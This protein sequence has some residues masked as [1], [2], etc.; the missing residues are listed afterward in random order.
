M[1]LFLH[2]FWSSIYTIVKLKKIPIVLLLV[3]HS[4]LLSGQTTLTIEGTVEDNYISGTWEGVN[5]PRNQPT[6]FTYRN[7]SVTSVNASGYML[8]AGDE[9]LSGTNNNLE[10]EVITGNR[11]TW[12]G[13][14][15]Q[16][17]THGVFT[18][19]NINAVLKYNY[20]ENVPMGLIR[21][22]NG[23]TNTSGGI[24]YN[25]VNK[26]QATG[27]VVKGMN[28]VNI[29]NNT[30]Y[31]DQ[32]FYG[33]PG[34]GT[35]RGLVDIYINTDITPN[36]SSRGT[37]IKNNI[38]Y[39]K[40]Q[41][42][43]IYIYESDCLNGFESDYNLFY[44][45][46]GTP[47]FNY[48]GS[49]KTF[50]QWQALGYDAHS[51]VVNPDFKD[52][53]GFVP[54]A[55]LDYGTDLGTT[56]QK[57]LSENAVWGATDPETTNQN[58]PWQV[59]ARI[60]SSQRIPVTDIY[61]TGAGGASTITSDNGTLQLNATVLPSNATDKTITWS[62]SNGADKAFIG[63][64][65]LVTAVDNGTVTAMATARDGS[66]ITGTYNITISN[67]IVPVSSI[68]VSGAGGATIIAS[69][70]GSLQLNA[71]VLPSGASNKTVTWSIVS[72]TGHATI[73]ATGLVTAVDNGTVTARASANDGSNVSGSMVIT[74]SNQIIRVTGISVTGAG[75]A[76]T[77]TTDHGSLQLNETVLPV[78]ATDKTVTWSIVNGSGQATISATGIVT[79]VENGVVT[80]RATAN[81]GSNVYGT[82]DIAI[83]NQT[84]QVIG[85]TI[86]GAGGA[87]TIIT[88]DGTLQISAVVLPANATNKTVTWSIVNGTELATISTTGLVTA[89]DNGA[90]TIRAT[91]NDGSNV[92]GTLVITIS[93]QIVPVTGINLIGSGGSST[94]TI[95]NG[96][97]QVS[98]VVL[99]AN[100]TNKSVTWSLINGTGQA[101][102]NA[103][104]IV[105]A[106][107]NG[108]VTARATANDGSNIFGSLVIT[109]SNQIIPVTS[110]S[111]TG[112]GGAT[113]ITTDNGSLQLSETVLPGNSTIKSVTWSIFI[114][115]GQALI[116]PSGLLTALDNGIVTVRATANDGSGVFGSL[117]ITISNQIIPV[118]NIN[119]TGA[120]GST[121]ITA[122]NG[123]LQLTA[124][125]LP[126]DATNK[127]VT[128]TMVNGSGQGTIDA[129]GLVTAIANGTVTAVATASDASGVIG[130]LAVTINSS[131]IP[132]TSI[133]VTG[134]GGISTIT[135]NHGSLQLSEAVLPSNATDNTVTWTL[136]NGTGQANINSTGL[137]TAVDNGTVTARATANDGSGVFGNLVITISNQT[138][139]V[140]GITISGAGGA[141]TITTDDGSLQLIAT[142]LP[143]DA[144]INS[145]TWSI[146]NG[147]GQA[148]ISSG[149]LVTAIN[150]GTVTATATANDGSGVFGSM[151][152]NL[153]NQVV[154]VT[155]I[156]VSGAGG[157]TSI[158][159]D[160]GTLQLSVSV[161]PANATDNTVI[162]SIV[163]STGQATISATG[164]VTAIDNGTVTARATANDGSGISGTLDINISDQM[165]PVSAV[166]VRG[167]GGATTI[168]TDNGSLQLSAELLPVNATDQTVTWSLISGASLANISTTGLVTALDNGTITV[169]AT[170][171]D[172]SGVY[173][174]LVITI[175]N[176]VISVTSITV[177]GSGGRTTI[178]NDNGTL[179]LFASV[180]PSNASNKAVTWS[181]VSGIGLAVINSSG[182]VTALDN[183]SV[184]ARATARDGSGVYGTIVITISNQVIPVTSISVTGTGSETTISTDNGSLQLTATV[185]PVNATNKTVTWS[186][187]NGTG[188]ATINSSGLVTAVENGTVT[189]MA[190]AN[191]G[192][193]V[194][195]N[196]VITISNQIVPVTGITVAGSGGATIITAD[197]G[198]LQLNAVVLPANATDKTVTWSLINGNGR[199][200]INSTGL[201]SAIDNGTV[202]AIATANDGSGIYASLV[203]DIF[204]QVIPVTGI[205]VTGSGGVSAIT[206]NNGTLQMSAVVMPANAS[207]KSVTWTLV[208]G[209]GLAI[210]N[211][212][213]FV[214][215]INNGA[216]T[217]RATANDGSGVFGEMLITISNQTGPVTAITVTGAGGE[218]SINTNKGSLQLTA[219]IVPANATIQTVSWSFVSGTGLATINATGLVSAIENGTVTVRATA[220]DGS[221]VYG[222]IVITISNQLIQITGI[223][224]TGTGGANFIATDNGTLQLSSVIVPAS[225]LNKSVTW[226]IIQGT[227]QATINN[228]GLVTAVDNGTVTAMA[229]ANDG[230]G[231]YGVMVIY[232]SAQIT[233][234]SSITVTGADGI[235]AI[236]DANV[237]IQLIARVMPV[238]ATNSRVTWSLVKGRE[239]AAIDST[240]LVTA[241]NNGI[242]TV[243]ATANDGSGVYGSMVIPI[244]VED[245]E[246]SLSSVTRDEI[247]IKLN[248]NYFSWRAGLYSIQGSLLQSKLVNS[249]V[250]VF[251]ISSLHSGLYIVVLSKGKNIRMAKVIKP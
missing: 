171:N 1:C 8:Q 219:V 58:G 167:A 113:T 12:N 11:F 227:G 145:V 29:Y 194:R 43:N 44:C 84:I 152:L 131:L 217:V 21:K 65:G 3:I 67:Q 100:A 206:V 109:I 181:I 248:N 62:I 234:V 168:T 137:V 132:V 112:A 143:V 126:A 18:G 218:T 214:T 183:G 141:T 108:T 53:T 215:A 64:N 106:I 32:V 247:K 7:N 221:G 59:G 164:L 25:I 38:F 72:G 165:V 139:L 228:I 40:H 184:T 82:I 173:G 153:S 79:A 222:T 185:L 120:G 56:W 74:I 47:L 229:T 133:A 142:V 175:T 124:H 204:N 205:T 138:I 246:L 63:T 239:L 197:N 251:D 169:R 249:D 208:N 98:A 95:D 150:N 93:N 127:N 104:G 66:G 39:T 22:S 4:F 125:V 156:S 23:M 178:T 24:A 2:K 192:S 200:V 226:S 16:S 187:V 201:V 172:G 160:N 210:I 73:N 176:Q 107:D 57:G 54:N 69:D 75:G 42:Y 20:L 157:A 110:I 180:L 128:W 162:W 92:Y 209:T 86:T 30:L 9:G 19:F 170:A 140:T 244:F 242:V 231:V 235:T 199:A 48:L 179:Q 174:T 61:I 71:T 94:I 136:I 26:T 189:A 76:T 155:N 10:G 33:G 161:L 51:V 196:L 77:I 49:V 102:I 191:D 78:N 121:I 36:G 177:T 111:V 97:L 250:L 147:T 90:V 123:T 148:N 186:I 149:G 224:V 230:S 37:K 87:T 34:I 207:D 151:V 114:G 15:P 202:T 211:T 154:H 103:T 41:I 83:S 118:T 245:F 91:A 105:T 220:N 159:T 5:I 216:V 213:G 193:G 158:S 101:T 52:F 188:Q 89:R 80:A 35:W 203:I 243:K 163:N 232:I 88:D 223:T 17:I 28:G 233:P 45:E 85:I 27:I 99:P 190:T 195:G 117:D 70:K 135:S 237:S 68:I 50:A 182:R 119:I 130:T 236:T 134:A 238:S 115:T 144:A 31:S 60:Y 129:T 46:S 241:F 198:S 55:R 116:S 122:E 96:T 14:D 146:V 13:T 81:D 166:T 6:I 240:G 212:S 225:A